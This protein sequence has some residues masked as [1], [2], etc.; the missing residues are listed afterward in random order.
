MG[1]ARTQLLEG[2]A[3]LARRA[4][5]DLVLGRAAAGL[6]YGT[7]PGLVAA[8]LAG[9][10]S[11]PAPGWLIASVCAATGLAAGTAAALIS[12]IDR[13]QLLIQADSVLGSRELI[14]TA[15]ELERGPGGAFAD[16]VVEDASALLWRTPPRVILARPRLGFAPYAGLALFLTAAALVFP[17]DLR[18]LLPRQSDQDRELAQIGE[19]LRKKG[20]KLAEDA[21]AQEL[22]R[23][24]ELSQQLAQLGHDLVDRRVTPEEA[25][26][27]MSQMESDLSREYQL[28]QQAAQADPSRVPGPAGKGNGESSGPLKPGDKAVPDNGQA[29]RDGSSSED[30]ATKDLGDALD[31]LRRAQRDLRDR[32]PGGDQGQGTDQARRPGRSPGQQGQAGQSGRGLPPSA[33]QSDQQGMDQGPGGQGKGSGGAEQPGE[34]GSSGVG[35][36]PDSQKRGPASDI[37]GGSRGPALQAQG[38]PGEGDSTRLLARSLPEWTGSKLPEDTILNRYSRQAESALSRDDV[39]LELRQSVKEYFTSIGVTK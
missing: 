14:S 17:V 9:T 8:V 15:L 23:S 18:A 33:G 28:R 21:R 1:D 26:D 13:R 30:P 20:E 24:L 29:G 32:A 25:L 16:A 3:R 22:G 5:L 37:I 19:D 38:T 35:T 34:P 2:T 4:R 36:Q 39:P 31:R 10:F 6:F 27:R 7:L 11:L 12:R